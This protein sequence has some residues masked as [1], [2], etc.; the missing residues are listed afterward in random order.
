MT[1]A[2]RTYSSRRQTGFAELGAVILLYAAYELLR[3]LGDASLAVA[4]DQPGTSSSWS[5]PWASSS[6]APSRTGP[7]RS[8]CCPLCSA[9]PT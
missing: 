7:P 4:R 5:S 2:L 8:R 3:G 6:N 9:W 1:A